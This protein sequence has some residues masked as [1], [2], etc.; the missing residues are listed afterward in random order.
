M[1]VTINLFLSFLALI[2]LSNLAYG[3]SDADVKQVKNIINGTNIR[4]SWQD[5][6]AL[7]WYNHYA[8]YY[9]CSSGRVQID[10][11]KVSETSSISAKR[12]ENYSSYGTW[13][14]I[15]NSGYVAIHIVWDNNEY[16]ILNVQLYPNGNFW[17]QG[18][19]TVERIGKI[20][21]G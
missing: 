5:G 9:F 17:I 10:Y 2:N 16:T 13:K 14:I 18:Y 7:M 11:T 20:E 12:R 1:K 15:K 19:K 8:D 21:C 4:V 3:Q 6:T